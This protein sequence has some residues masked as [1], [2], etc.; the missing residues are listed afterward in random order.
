VCRSN[1]L[2]F[3]LK[4]RLGHYFLVERF[5]DLKL[6]PRQQVAKNWS[7]LEILSKQTS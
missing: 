2:P 3:I 7:E 5:F 1:G 4:S 6:S